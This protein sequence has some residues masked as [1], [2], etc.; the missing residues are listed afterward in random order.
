MSH[1]LITIPVE[2]ADVKVIK[3][4]LFPFL[5]EVGD[6]SLIVKVQDDNEPSPELQSALRN[7]FVYLL[8]TLNNSE[9]EA[10]N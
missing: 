5:E 4:Q 8:C 6:I 7:L 10:L 9:F 2:A 3:A 1:Y